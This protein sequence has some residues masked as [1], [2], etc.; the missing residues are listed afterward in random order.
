MSFLEKRSSEDRFCVR[1][2]VHVCVCVAEQTEE[3][4]LILILKVLECMINL[5]EDWYFQA[6]QRT[7]PGGGGTVGTLGDFGVR[8]SAS[9]RTASLYLLY[10]WVPPDFI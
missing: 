6:V 9:G 5:S 7:S 2:C 10:L 3:M 8:S 1:V 4:D